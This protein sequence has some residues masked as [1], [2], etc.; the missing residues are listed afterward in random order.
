MKKSFRSI[1]LLGA[2][3]IS[4]VPSFA[5]MSGGNP[6]PQWPSQGSSS[7]WSGIVAAAYAYVGI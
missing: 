6:R 2:L 5:A 7:A 1:V 4:A 3:A